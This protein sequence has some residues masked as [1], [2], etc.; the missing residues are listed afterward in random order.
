M[1]LG[2]AIKRNSTLRLAYESLYVYNS[3]L[4]KVKLGEGFEDYNI[5]IK[6]ESNKM[7][8]GGY[9]AFITGFIFL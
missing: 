3:R 4:P 9:D 8:E 1:T 6:D 5:S 2:K 7:H